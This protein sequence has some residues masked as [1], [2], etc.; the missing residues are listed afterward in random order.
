MVLAR[1]PF[2]VPTEPIFAARSELFEDSFGQY[3]L[4]QAVLRFRQGI[5]RLIRGSDD[6]GAIVVLDRRISA[7]AYGKAFLQSMPPCTELRVPVGAVPAEAA[8]WVAGGRKA[9][10]D[11]LPSS[12]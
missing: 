1:L 7:R 11:D 2:H 4:P 12:R 8:R 9:N 10:A 5:G 6:R 3:A